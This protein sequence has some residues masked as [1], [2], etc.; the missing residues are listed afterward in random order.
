MFYTLSETSDWQIVREGNVKER[1]R[2][3][4]LKDNGR[5]GNLKDSV[6]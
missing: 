5:E 1:W 2:E 4:N 3:G 6:R